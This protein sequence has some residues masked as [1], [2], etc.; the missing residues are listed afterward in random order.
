L[1]PD[2]EQFSQNNSLFLTVVVL[3][4]LQIDH[5][6]TTRFP[7]FVSLAAIQLEHEKDYNAAAHF[8]DIYIFYAGIHLH[9][10]A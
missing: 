8:G 3:L 7:F 4:S 10:H 2:T 1:S 6:Y 5:D 9:L